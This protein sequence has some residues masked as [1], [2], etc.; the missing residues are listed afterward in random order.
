VPET[1]DVE[2]TSTHA[3]ES[4]RLG[5]QIASPQPTRRA[6]SLRIHVGHPQIYRTDYGGTTR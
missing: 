4:R 2:L 6:A 5:G 1:V 3:P